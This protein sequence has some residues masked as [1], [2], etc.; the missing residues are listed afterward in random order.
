MS[1]T[2]PLRSGAAYRWVQKSGSRSAAH[3]ITPKLASTD[4]RTYLVCGRSMQTTRVVASSADSPR[5]GSCL[6]NIKEGT[7]LA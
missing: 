3:A 5:C 7:R 6:R 1:T 2:K 4:E